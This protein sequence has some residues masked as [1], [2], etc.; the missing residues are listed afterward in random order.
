MIATTPRPRLPLGDEAE[1]EET[2]ISWV[3]LTGDR[4]F[5]VKKPVVLPFVDYGTPARRLAMCR[6]EVELNRRLAPDVYLGVRSLVPAGGGRLELGAEDD[7]D[8]VDYAV[9]MRRY[10]ADA[11]LAARLAAGTAGRAELTAVG[12]RLA[13]FHAKAQRCPTM[14]GAEAAKRA[15]DDNFASLRS[16][17]QQQSERRALARAERFASAFLTRAWDELQRR[18]ASGMVRDCHG[19]LRL[20]HVLLESGVDVVDCVEF[21]AGLRQI[22]VA[23]DLAFLVMELHEAGRPDLAAVL[24]R[25]YR[26]AGGDPGSDALLAFFAAYR[27]QVRAKVA[28]TRGTQLAPGAAAAG[29]GVHASALLRLGE[30]LQ[31]DART[32]LVVVIAG[33]AASGKTTLAQALADESGFAHL[34]SDVVR[35]RRAGLAPTDRAPRALYSE[36]TNRATYAALGRRAAETAK[37]GVVVDATFRNRADRD[38]FCERLPTGTPLLV[39]ECRA[40]ADVLLARADARAR[41][42]NGASDAGSEIVRRQLRTHDPLDEFDARDHVLVRADQPAVQLVAAIADAL[43]RRLIDR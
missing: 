25:A 31:W 22:D 21:N 20:E 10:A 23:A 42:T 36:E 43:D 38:V 4:A 8:A 27:A 24:A 9:E 37:T 6:A 28:L 30:R 3:F 41:Q 18:G 13:R 15:V 19:D 16:L 11:T 7:P 1:I 34:N 40:P 33:V 5:K 12:E 26:T 32:P 39:V 29:E 17:L 35:K 2:H 14:N